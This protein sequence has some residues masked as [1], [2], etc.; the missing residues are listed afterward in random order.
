MERRAKLRAI[1][2]IYSDISTLRSYV[3]AVDVTL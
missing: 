1:K 2:Q 3:P